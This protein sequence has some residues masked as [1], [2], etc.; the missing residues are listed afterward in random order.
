[1]GRK[2]I[3]SVIQ[4]KVTAIDWVVA[5]DID[6]IAIS[7]VG[8]GDV[9]CVVGKPWR[10]FLVGLGDEGGVAVGCLAA[11]E[12]VLVGS[13]V[14]AGVA[15]GEHRGGVDDGDSGGCACNLGCCGD[16]ADGGCGA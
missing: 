7:I 8:F 11:G 12:L 10:D 1:M 13:E 14:D 5:I 9:G 3:E 6:V 15:A 16:V 2:Q 4:N